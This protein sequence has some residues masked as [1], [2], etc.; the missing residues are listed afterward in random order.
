MLMTIAGRMLLIGKK[1]SN[2]LEHAAG[3]LHSFPSIDVQ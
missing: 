2:E 3:S 1:F